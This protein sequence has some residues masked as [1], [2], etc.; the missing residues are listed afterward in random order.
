MRGFGE[1]FDSFGERLIL[2]ALRLMQDLPSNGIQ[3][4]KVSCMYQKRN[5]T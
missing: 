4:R 3:A 5:Q 2:A 1:Q